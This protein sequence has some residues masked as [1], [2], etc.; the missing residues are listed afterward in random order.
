MEE[1]KELF[2]LLKE[3]IEK[4]KEDMILGAAESLTKVLS[5]LI[6]GAILFLFGCIILLL[7]CI[8]LAF[9]I[10]EYIGSTS[11]GFAV[12]AGIILALVLLFWFNRKQWV[13][14]S[15]ASLMIQVF[16]GQYRSKDNDTI[17]K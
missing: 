6:T 8:A 16:F 13:V 7:A 15:I 11:T 1:F 17:E 3:Y 12:M 10:G 5:A 9:L 4:Q 2:L 14:Q